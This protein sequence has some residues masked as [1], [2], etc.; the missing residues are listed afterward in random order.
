MTD[1]LFLLDANVLINAHNKYYPVDMVPEFWDWLVHMGTA[2][3]IKMP[4]ETFEE[5]KGGKEDLLTKWMA[6]AEIEAA[7]VFDESADI[8]AVRTVTEVGYAPDLTDTEVEQIGRDP[9][10]VA[11][12][13]VDPAYRVVVTEEVSKPSKQRANRKVPDVCNTFGVEHCNTFYLLRA[14]GFTTGWNR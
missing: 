4:L 2:G 10:L 11:Y 5:V 3:R 14:L 13:L 1:K 12:G 9:F 7:L 8:G 6:K